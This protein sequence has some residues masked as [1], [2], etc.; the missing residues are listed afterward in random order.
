MTFTRSEYE[1]LKKWWESLDEDEA[2]DMKKAKRYFAI[3]DLIK[4]QEELN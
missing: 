3:R 4:F 2:C 1:E